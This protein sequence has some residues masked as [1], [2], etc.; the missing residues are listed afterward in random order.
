MRIWVPRVL[1]FRGC[2]GLL[3]PSHC[4]F[5]PLAIIKQKRTT[6]WI[7]QIYQTHVDKVVKI[8]RL[9]LLVAA[10]AEA[11]YPPGRLEVIPT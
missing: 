10:E 9:P 8:A 4:C 11:L 1:R 3:G 7:Y 2:Q 6:S 5:T